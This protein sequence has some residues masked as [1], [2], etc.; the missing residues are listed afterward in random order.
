T[1]YRKKKRHELEDDVKFWVVILNTVIANAPAVLDAAR[2]DADFT[3]AGFQKG[4]DMVTC[5]LNDYNDAQSSYNQARKSLNDSLEKA[6]ELYHA[7]LV[8]PVYITNM[9]AERIEAAKAKYCPTHEELNPNMRF[10]ENGYVKAIAENEEMKEYFKKNPFSWE[11]DYYMLKDILEKIKMS[12]AY[13]NYMKEESTDFAADCELWRTLLRTVVFPSDALAEAMESR[14]VYWN[15]D[16]AIMGTFVLKTIKHFASSASG[17][18]PLLP[19]YKDD[20][21]ARF[22]PDLFLDAIKN[23]E[24]Y[25]SYID[26][27]INGTSWDPERLAFMDIVILITAITEMVK[28]PAIPIAVTMNEYVEI[29]N[30]YSTARSGQFVNGI[31]FSIANYLRQEGKITK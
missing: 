19:I 26:M 7:L 16:L 14:S 8:L 27:F 18:A 10:V 1:D 23:R 5:T 9:E 13:R 30:Y 6:Y 4:V 11:N 25:R 21:D 31:L 12:E 3:L 15:D 29:A 2:A 20:E 17:H 22:G 28:F 24:Q